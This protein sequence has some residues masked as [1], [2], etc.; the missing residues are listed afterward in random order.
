MSDAIQL[1]LFKNLF[2][3][4]AE[5][6]GVVL[7]RTAL[8]TNI[9]ER[10]DFS[11]ALFDRQ[12]RMLAQAAHIPVHLGSTPMSVAA[13][14]DTLAMRPG[15]HVV[16]ND[17]YCGGTHLPDITCVTPVFVEGGDEPELYVANRA[18]HADIGSRSISSMPIAEHIDDEGFRFGPTIADERFIEELRG[19]VHLPDEREADLRAQIAANHVGARRLTGLVEEIGRQTLRERGEA[20]LDYGERMMRRVLAA[21]PDG[22]YEAEERLDSDGC[23]SFDIPLRV[24]IEIDGETARIDFAGSAPQ[25]KGGINAV[26][27]VTY[28]ATCYAF[29]LLA[30]LEMPS[31]GGY[32]RALEVSAPIGSVL[33][34][35]YPAPVAGGNVE[36]S[37]RVV[38]VVLRALSIAAPELVPAA[39]AGTMNNV[40]IGGRRDDAIYAYYETIGGGSGGAPDGDGASGVQTHMTNTR[41]TPIEV[42]EHRYPFRILAYELI[43]GSGGAGLHR[44]GDGLRRHYQFLAPADVVVITERRRHAPYGLQGGAPGRRGRNIGPHGIEWPAKHSVRVVAGDELVIETPGGGGWGPPD[45]PA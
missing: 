37:Q 4:I 24:A 34:A 7:M 2:A 20:L 41:N 1:E 35:R 40:A 43:D 9:K 32:L 15:Q 38:D 18:H 22:R 39:S 13:A 11:C 28:S 23:G 21:L 17:P 3:A 6:M 45:E 5:E 29:R 31:N 33:N 26:Y 8:S 27:A 30:P 12:G 10:L 16:L 42:L 36:T 25:V 19:R 14:I 44:G